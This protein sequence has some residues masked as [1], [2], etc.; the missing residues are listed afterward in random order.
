L[1]FGIAIGMLKILTLNIGYHSDK[2]G[3]WEKRRELGRV[4]TNH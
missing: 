1:G 4:N 3:L 2:H